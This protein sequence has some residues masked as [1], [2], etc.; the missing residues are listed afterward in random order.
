MIIA[1]P[2]HIS[3][4]AF[5]TVASITAA[6][7]AGQPLVVLGAGFELVRRYVVRWAHLVGAQLVQQLVAAVE[8]AYVSSEEFVL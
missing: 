7:R 5:V 1:T 6:R 4:C 2:Q 8:G 3:K